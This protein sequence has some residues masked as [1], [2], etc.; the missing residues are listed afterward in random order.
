MATPVT[1]IKIT[2]DKKRATWHYTAHNNYGGSFGSTHCGS[3]KVA[4]GM[5]ALGVKVGQYFEV[6]TNG[7]S[8][9]MFT[10]GYDGKVV[11]A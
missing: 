1:I 6:V 7:R 9:G 5:A 8:E 3:K 2:L 4:L 11:K 10:T